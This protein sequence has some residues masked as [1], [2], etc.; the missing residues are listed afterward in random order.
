M[1][2]ELLKLPDILFAK[3]S[4]RRKD[5]KAKEAH[6]V[7]LGAFVA[8][9]GM[10]MGIPFSSVL[11][12]QWDKSVFGLPVSFLSSVP[13]TAELVAI[14][15]CSLLLL[16]VYKRSNLRLVLILSAGISVVANALCFFAYSPEQ[17]ILLRFFSGVGFAGMK[18][19]LNA[20]VSESSANSGDITENL[21]AQNAGLL[22][23]ITCGGTLGGIIAG[24]WAFRQP[25][26][27]R[28]CSLRLSL[29][30][31]RDLYRGRL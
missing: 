10:Y 25:I 21:A 22:G 26:S 28:R 9:T 13:M 7:R 20:V 17:L 15:A 29:L 27:L 2:F 30:S 11:T 31:W 14:T 24:L 4:N 12:T 8:Y 23:G 1:I 6:T 16:P 3:L 19:T 5:E 18:Y